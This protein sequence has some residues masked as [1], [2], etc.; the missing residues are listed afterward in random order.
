MDTIPL[1]KKG[2]PFVERRRE[3]SIAG[4]RKKNGIRVQILARV[5]EAKGLRWGGNETSAFLKKN[6]A[7]HDRARLHLS[8]GDGVRTRNHRIDNPVL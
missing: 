7:S 6:E 4:H 1:M 8:E 5:G 2:T 3:R